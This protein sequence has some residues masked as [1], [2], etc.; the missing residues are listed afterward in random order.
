MPDKKNKEI[1]N[2][3]LKEI[4]LSAIQ[5]SEERMTEKLDGITQEL[6]QLTISTLETSYN[7]VQS[8]HNSLNDMVYAM[9]QDIGDLKKFKKE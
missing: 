1:S 7:E 3:E 9:H 4:L 2:N 6:N 8:N 5:K